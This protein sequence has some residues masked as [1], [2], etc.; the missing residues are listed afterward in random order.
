[1]AACPALAPHV[2]KNQQCTYT[3]TKV[4][5]VSQASGRSEVVVLIRQDIGE[6][7]ALAKLPGN[8]PAVAGYQEAATFNKGSP[9]PAGAAVIPASSIV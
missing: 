5:E 3:G 7:G 4:V 2:V 8:N 1:L 9:A 6:R